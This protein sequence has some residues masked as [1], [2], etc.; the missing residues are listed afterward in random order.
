MLRKIIWFSIILFVGYI[1]FSEVMKSCGNNATAEQ[2]SDLGAS[3]DDDEETIF[4][5]ADED[6]GDDEYII[7]DESD[8]EDRIAEASGEVNLKEAPGDFD[9]ELEET[10]G[11]EDFQEK[12]P[13][14]KS[15][16]RKAIEETTYS[17]SENASYLVIAGSFSD[18]GNADRMVEKLNKMGFAGAEKIVFDF[19]QYYSV[20]TGK[21]DTES[22]ARAKSLELKDQN[23]NAYV[24]KMRSKLFGD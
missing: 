21:Y 1:W 18:E 19:S 4:K 11:K 15:I 2:M 22:S 17:S 20:V 5:A 13:A 16:S 10:E 8:K 24:H 9:E 7:A 14:K 12:S 23:I 3:M 6:Y